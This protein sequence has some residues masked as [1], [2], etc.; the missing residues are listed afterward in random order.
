M[1]TDLF[2]LVTVLS[3]IGII[4]WIIVRLE[5][6]KR[7]MRTRR[8]HI[9]DKAGRPRIQIG[10]TDEGLAFMTFLDSMGNI[11]VAAGA[12]SLLPSSLAVFDEAGKPA[13]QLMQ[14]AHSPSGLV[15]SDA[16]GGTRAV[17]SLNKQGDPEFG[18]LD[19]NGKLRV[20]IRV[21]DRQVRLA[22]LDESATERFVIAS[23]EEG[24]SSLVI[25]DAA[26]TSLA[27][28]PGPNY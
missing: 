9:M 22:I 5:L 23:D 11:R 27:R 17:L 7:D 14:S 3:P 4:A 15:L 28:I 19:S 13:V 26:G 21:A 25:L 6:M 24:V 2:M 16:K 20:G 8:L 18:V 1:I 10:T 12:H